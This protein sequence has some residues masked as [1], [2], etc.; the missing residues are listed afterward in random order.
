MKQ[1]GAGLSDWRPDVLRDF[2]GVVNRRID[3]VV[4]G[5][6][7]G[8]TS[9]L[10]RFLR[11]HP[12]ICMASTK[13]LHFFDDDRLFASGEP[14]Y[15]I[16]HA[17]FS[18]TPSARVLGEAT[19]VYMYWKPAAARMRAYN[20]ALKLIVI[21]RNPIDRA[22]SHWKMT[23]RRGEESLDFS[24]AIRTEDERC[25]EAAPAQHRFY[26]YIDRGRYASQLRRLREFFPEEQ[27]LVLRN[28][29]LRADAQV[30]MDRVSGFLGV[31]PAPV[32]QRPLRSSEDGTAMSAADR[33][34]LAQA[35]SAE[36]D[37][38]EEMLGWD[39][40]GWRR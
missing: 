2:R 11:M 1:P 31:D 21:L 29:E 18:P 10:A 20:P 28:E 17:Q 14:D 9:A 23:T 36:L 22:W 26:S 5:T 7:K 37:A 32:R 24:T 39:C 13:E 3:F 19:P 15:E 33:E 16:Y 25:R 27:I 40:S 30:V 12:Q 35:F 8:G 4:A 34:F 6:Q 38:L